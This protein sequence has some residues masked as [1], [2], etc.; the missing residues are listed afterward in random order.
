MSLLADMKTLIPSGVAT[1]TSIYLGDYPDTPDNIVALYHSGGAD[2]SH[3]FSSREF[4][5]PTFQVRIRNVS[6]AMAETKANA[7]KD[8][9]DGLTE[10]SINGNRYLSIFQQGDILPLGKDS[11]NRTELTLNIRVKVKRA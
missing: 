1:A 6:F 4:E 8:V 10:Q 7:I 2:P 3:T 5:E 11:K 9:L